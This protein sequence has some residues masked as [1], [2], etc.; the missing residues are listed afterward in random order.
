MAPKSSILGR[1]CSW[2]ALTNRDLEAKIDPLLLKPYGPKVAENKQLL[3]K[4][5]LFVSTF[6]ALFLLRLSNKCRIQVVLYQMGANENRWRQPCGEN[7][8]SP[9]F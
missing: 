8:F 7:A 6:G 3:A 9:Y 4:P 5:Q 1:A 2:R